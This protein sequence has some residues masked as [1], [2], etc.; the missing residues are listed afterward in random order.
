MDWRLK[1]GAFKT[2]LNNENEIN[3]NSNTE[4]FLKDAGTYSPSPSD[5]P[6][7]RGTNTKTGCIQNVYAQPLDFAQTCICS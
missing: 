3:T 1:A 5:V 2:K 7:S 6:S 4:Q